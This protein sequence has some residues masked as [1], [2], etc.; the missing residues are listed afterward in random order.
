MKKVMVGIL[1]IIPVIIVLVVAFVSVF[2]SMSAHIAVDDI[3]LDKNYIELEY[4]S[5]VSAYKISNLVNAKITPDRASNKTITWSISDVVCFDDD[6]KEMWDAGT[7]PPPAYLCEDESGEILDGT[8]YADNTCSNDGYIRINTYCSF[9]LKAQAETHTATCRALVVG[10]KVESISLTCSDSILSIGENAMIQIETDPIEAIV[11]TWIYES[12]DES[13]VTIDQN[14]VV[15]AEGAGTA[16][17]TVKASVYGEKD[18]FVEST[19]NLTVLDDVTI[20]GNSIKTAKDEILFAEIGVKAKDAEIFDGAVLNSNGDGFILTD[21]IAVLL[22]GGNEL[23]VERCEAGDIVIDNANLFEAKDEGGYVLET[24]GKLYLTASFVDSFVTSKPNVTW[25]SNRTTVAKVDGNGIVTGVSN[26]RVIITATTD[27]GK[28]AS[29]TI[30]VQEVV[31]V[32]LIETPEQCSNQ[33]IAR[34]TING[35]MVYVDV[36]QDVDDVEHFVPNGATFN[37]EKTNNSVEF[38]FQRPEFPEGANA[39]EFYSAFNFKVEEYVG[40]GE[41]KHLEESNKAWFEA[42]RMYFNGDAI[43]GLTELV[44]TIS[45]KYPKFQSRPEYTTVQFT[46]KVTKGVEV[47]SWIEALALAEENKLIAKGNEKAQEKTSTWDMILATNIARADGFVPDDA[48]IASLEKIEDKVNDGRNLSNSDEA[49]WL[50]NGG[51]EGLN[52]LR[53]MTEYVRTTTI[54]MRGNLYGN[55]NMIYGFKAQYDNEQD[56]LLFVIDDGVKISNVILRVC[57]VGDQIVDDAE[58]AQGLKGNAVRIEAHDTGDF[59]LRITD[60]RIEYS[61]LENG[62]TLMR[63]YN[64]DVTLD[65]CILRNTSSAAMYVPTRRNKTGVLYSHLTVNNC[66]FSNMLSTALNAFFDGYSNDKDPASLAQAEKDMAEG[67]TF[68]LN[69]TGFIDIYNWHPTDVLNFMADLSD[70]NIPV[71]GNVNLNMFVTEA[72]AENTEFKQYSRIYQQTEYFHM[73]LVVSG[74][75][76]SNGSFGFGKTYHICT[77]EDDRIESVTTS[78]IFKSNGTYTAM[79]NGVLNGNDIYLYTYAQNGNLT[80]DTTYQVNDRL[81][82]H[83][84][85][86]I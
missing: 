21:D 7:A 76:K 6:Y 8:D 33:G 49:L 53:D 62:E 15:N 70:I 81:I 78:Q 50:E 26:G 5:T 64:G 14:G 1:V 79:L 69:Q 72:L 86:E 57:E 34:E 12:S 44:V 55:G 27:D 18:K 9:V 82:R 71:L 48:L 28:S 46:V 30:N 37:V 19:I 63:S 85:G 83:L 52:Y 29:V 13:I 3:T 24:E 58:D 42:N 56:S 32:L 51:S 39:E 77:F 73:G 84:H 54:Y 35:S 25:T 43:D 41:D 38:N 40:Q 67:R 20:Y 4:D 22:I 16:T 2:V 75:T 36:L 45:A 66:V 59:R 47:S 11:D 23:T 68:I 61:I 10:Y 17:I 74:I 31:T 60:T 80:P 65:G